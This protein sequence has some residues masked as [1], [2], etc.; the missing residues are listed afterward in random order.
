ML[1][2]VP[3]QLGG[4]ESVVSTI[5]DVVQGLGVTVLLPIIILVI[6]KAFRV[7]TGKAVKSSILIGV[8]FQGIFLVLGL[9]NDNISPLADGMVQATGITLPVVDVGWPAAAAIAFGIAQLGIWVIPIFVVLN[10]AL[11][12][13]GFTYTLDVDIWNYWHF[14]F[15]AGIVF[16]ATDNW[17][18][19]MAIGM[20]L[21]TFVLVGADWFQPAVE[22]TFD[23]P[24]ISIPHAGSMPF[25]VA[26]I[27]IYEVIKR[28]P[29]VGS[30]TWDPETIQN[31]LGVLGEPIFLGL[32]LGLLI[33]IGAKINA[34]GQLQS[35]YAILGAAIAF[36]AVMHILPM[37]VGIL[38]EGLTPLSESIRD[39]MTS[40][41]EGRDFAIGLDSA[42]L[43]G[44]ESVIAASLV[45]VP[46]AIAMSIVLPG[47]RMLW[48]VDLATFPFF[49]AMMVP[50]MDGDVVDMVLTGIV[51]LVP[52]HY[53]SSAIAP[54]LTEAARNAG[55]DMPE[56]NLITPRSA[57]AGRRSRGFWRFRL[58]RW[59][60]RVRISAWRSGSSACSARGP[61]SAPGPSGCT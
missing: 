36:A 5:N 45:I 3:I 23:T 24:G 37:M 39:Y 15:I 42:I 25:A 28:L 54:L 44:H 4:L 29:V 41:Y 10:L 20:V 34:L 31:R 22:E 51:L 14:A 60:S 19:S 57:T 2:S 1:T 33:G 32:A 48:G 7:E 56:A 35:W 30:T 6:A 11:F 55:F 27:P 59:G 53:I 12:A 43:I 26:A 17:V 46:I 8:G 61:P 40:R 9:F 18:V 21:G 38:M 47:N 52:L 50:L 49:F 58:S 13:V 16:F